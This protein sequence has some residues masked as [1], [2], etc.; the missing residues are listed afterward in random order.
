MSISPF[1]ADIFAVLIR[2]TIKYISNFVFFK[3]LIFVCYFMNKSCLD[4]KV[5]CYGLTVGIICVFEGLRRGFFSGVR[6]RKV[7]FY[8][9]LILRLTSI[10]GVKINIFCYFSWWFEKSL[11]LCSAK[12]F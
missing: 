4:K 3:V 2:N 1:F 7:F 12:Y 6:A 5:D 8:L 11:Y 9:I 10:Y